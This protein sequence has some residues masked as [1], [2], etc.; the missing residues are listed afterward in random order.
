[1]KKLQ[2]AFAVLK[3]ET[4]SKIFFFFFFFFKGGVGGGGAVLEES[5]AIMNEVQ[6]FYDRL[7]KSRDVGDCKINELIS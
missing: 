6:C 4:I 1:M 7:Y 5:N 2:N 3:K